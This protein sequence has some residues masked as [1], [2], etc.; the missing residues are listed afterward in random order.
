[1]FDPLKAL[2]AI[3]TCTISPGTAQNW[4]PIGTHDVTIEVPHIW[5]DVLLEKSVGLVLRIR[6]LQEPRPRCK[7]VTRPA[8]HPTSGTG[9]SRPSGPTQFAW[10]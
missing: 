9:T 5:Y 2:R 7:T 6:V 1:M 4:N 3:V 8:D 10:G